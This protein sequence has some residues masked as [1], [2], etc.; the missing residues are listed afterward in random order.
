MD[1]RGRAGIRLV[2]L[3]VTIIDE[4]TGAAET[5]L[6]EMDFA[7]FVTTGVDCGE[8]TAADFEPGQIIGVPVV[9]VDGLD[10]T[11]PAPDEEAWGRA[12]LVAEC[13]ALASGKARTFEFFELGAKLWFC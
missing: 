6:V 11:P 4:A 12:W 3:L 5:G 8:K 7:C 10:T 13:Q 9:D 1:R 2:P